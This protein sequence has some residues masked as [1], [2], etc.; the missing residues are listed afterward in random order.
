METTFF[1]DGFAVGD[2]SVFGT[3]NIYVTQIY[4]TQF[5]FGLDGS[6]YAAAE[7]VVT[8]WDTDLE[9]LDAADPMPGYRAPTKSELARIEKQLVER[10]LSDSGWQSEAVAQWQSEQDGPGYFDEY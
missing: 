5:D 9:V 7:A 3:A 4:V 1:C 6:I 10:L 8:G 2:L